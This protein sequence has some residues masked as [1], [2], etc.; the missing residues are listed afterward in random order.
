ML[1]SGITVV[2]V[3]ALVIFFESGAVVV[4]IVSALVLF[5]CFL[6]RK[7][8]KN[9]IILPTIC[10][11][12]LI[13]LIS[14]FS[15]NKHNISPYLQYH[16]TSQTISGKIISSPRLI[17]NLIVFN[18]KA[19]SIGNEKIN[20]TIHVTLNNYS[21]YELELYDYIVLENAFISVPTD[22]DGAYDFTDFSDNII[23]SAKGSDAELTWSCDKTPYY[24]CIHIK[25]LITEK[26]NTYM[27]TDNGALLKGM[28]FGDKA[29]LSYETTVNFRNGGISHLLAVS[30]LHTSLWCGLL[31]AL[32]SA[33]RVPEKVRSTV[34]LI[35]LILFCI[36]SGFTPS[37]M[38]ASFMTAV[39]LVAPFFKRT[40]DSINSLGLAVA[41]LLLINP[42]TLL[43]ISF[44]LTASA[45]LGVLVASSLDS[46]ILS[47]IR[48]IPFNKL[49]NIASSLLTSILISLFAGLFTMPVS[50]YYF[51]V[52]S[53]ASPI[54]NLLCVQLAFYGMLAGTASVALSFI[55]VGFIKEIYIFTFKITEFILD[56]V[57]ELADF[58]S[59]FKYC[60]I[61]IHKEYLHIGIIISVI[62]STVGYLLFKTNKSKWALRLTA[63]V[64][65]LSVLISIFIPLFAPSHKNTITIADCGNGMQLI[66]RSGTSYA[67]I[68]NTTS[69]I[70]DGTFDALPKATCEQLKYYIPTYLSKSSIY[71]ISTVSYQYNPQATVMPSTVKATASESFIDIPEN[72]LIDDSGYFTLSDEIS[73]EIVDT[74]H[75][76]YA[77]IRGKD[78]VVFVHLYGDTDF[79][80]YV[81][82]ED[83]S[84]AVYN[85][86]AP[87]TIPQSAET[88]VISTTGYDP[89]KTNELSHFCE[90]IYITAKHG[91]VQIHM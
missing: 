58:V 77:I 83:C 91:S 19:D 28:L 26:I 43:S 15:Y 82:V 46:K 22:E 20:A 9:H 11:V 42:Y 39:T 55:P 45:T 5:L 66:V 33:F 24:Y 85:G 3:L 57:K 88:V 44:Q 17:S 79:S 89:I 37:V 81:S 59:D 23:L 6:F 29:D 52:F 62:F 41:V 40:P 31:I 75:I 69:E 64:A 76:K 63:V 80:K 34:C 78:N 49:R 51:E 30:G 73:L 16:K 90:D 65:S 54:S 60:T 48:K 84:V 68:E 36:I 35:F 32:L 1:I 13:T 86:N 8:L 2:I 14:F 47:L 61:P 71:N 12:A 56:V 72:T 10:V 50:A 21:E 27:T 25:E 67:Y 4:P 18:L 53:L 70:S 74:D 87:D 38:R 7:R